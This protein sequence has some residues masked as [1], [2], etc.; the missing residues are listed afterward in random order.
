[1]HK[2]TEVLCA[3]WFSPD[4]NDWDSTYFGKYFEIIKEKGFKFKEEQRAVQLNF[5]ITPHDAGT[6]LKT[7]PDYSEGEMRMIFKT[8]DRNKAII[9]SKN[10]ISFHALGE[11]NGWDNF[12]NELVTPFLQDYR[13]LGLGKD[14]LQV[15]SLYLNNFNLPIEQQLSDVF[16][17]IPNIFG[18]A[19]SSE[20]SMVYQ[21]QFN[22]D[23]NLS[24]LVKLNGGINPITNLKELVFECSCF[25]VNHE[26]TTEEQLISNAHEQAN[27][28]FLKTTKLL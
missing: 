22:L 11:Y 1:M 23:Q 19:P 9:L 25:A 14:T 26:K 28:I 4:N 21:S 8:E 12:I 6:G 3:F 24:V 16:S 10:F 27:S 15:Q 7:K 13:E 2:L 17:F 20:S 18:F 5:Q